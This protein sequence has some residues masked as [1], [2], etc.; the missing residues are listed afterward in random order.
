MSA[1][2][3]V[4]GVFRGG[5]EVVHGDA[6]R[7][8]KLVGRHAH[9]GVMLAVGDD[10][11]FD[12]EK[13][14]VLEVAERRTLLAR[15]R[16]NRGGRTRTSHRGGEEKVIAANMD[17]VAIV[18]AVERPPF[19]AGAVDRFMLAAAVGGLECVLVVNK[20]DLLAG[21]P[22]PDEIAS[23]AESLP[24]FAVSAH[25][26]LG[27]EALREA[28]RG[29]RTVLA[30]HSGVG[31]SSLLN[32]LEPE[33]RLE[34]GALR[35]GDQRGRHTTSAATWLRLQGDAVV[36]DTPGVREITTG[37]VDP[38]LVDEVFPDLAELAQGCRFRDCRH[39]QEPACA[40]RAAVSAGELARTR[41]D[42]YKKLIQDIEPA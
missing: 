39:D 1:S 24:L 22:L 5:C 31:K 40:V 10:V 23:Y 9:Q 33:L 41:L 32:A 14:I 18:A 35:R 15:L 19:R 12:P 20:I 17:R 38:A 42:R 26:G 13:G 30:G 36:V 27:L 8:L 6:L 21:A 3:T 34:T 37:P 29:S 2:G 4:I 7:E 16:P 28:L 25:E 11:S